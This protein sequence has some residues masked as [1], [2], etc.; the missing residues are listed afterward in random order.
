MF[1][2][3]EHPLSLYE[4]LIIFLHVGASIIG[5]AYNWKD[6]LYPKQRSG[7]LLVE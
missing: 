7:T 2:V 1:L 4:K 3:S 5:V 6:G